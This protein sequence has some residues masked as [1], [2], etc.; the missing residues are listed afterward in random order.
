MCLRSE[1]I[2]NDVG[3]VGRVRH[4]KGLSNN[5]GGVGRGRVISD[6]SEVLE[7][8]TEAAGDR[9]QAQGIYDDDGNVGGV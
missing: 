9:R 7:T 4:D 6:T 3:G 2:D 8:K 1:G 5:N